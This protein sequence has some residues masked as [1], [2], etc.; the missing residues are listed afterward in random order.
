MKG[1]NWF[2]NVQEDE[3]PEITKEEVLYELKIIKTIRLRAKPTASG[4]FETDR[5]RVE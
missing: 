4:N 2:N 3:D 1:R 5:R